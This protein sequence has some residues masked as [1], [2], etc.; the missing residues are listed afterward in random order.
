MREEDA[1]LNMWEDLIQG[2]IIE[3]GISLVDAKRQEKVRDGY[4]VGLPY[5]VV[6]AARKSFEMK[7]TK[8]YDYYGLLEASLVR[9]EIEPVDVGV[10]VEVG[11]RRNSGSSSCSG[12]RIERG[13]R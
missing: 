12:E 13:E 6:V 2:Y 9:S 10:E 4:P 8:Y 5:V 3:A 11:E 7:L 1:V